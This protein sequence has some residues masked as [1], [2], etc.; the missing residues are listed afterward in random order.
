MFYWFCHFIV[1]WFL[2]I[3]YRFRVEGLENFPQDGPVLVASNHRSNIDPVAIG[4]ALKREI[5]FM[6]KEE[7][8]K[9]P[10]LRFIIIQWKAF[11]VKRGVADRQAIKT[12]LDIMKS[13]K[14]LGLFPEG[15]RSKNG[16]LGPAQ[17][18][19]GL[20]AVKGDCLVVP[21]ALLGTHK[22]SGPITVRIGKPL[23]LSK[24][25]EER[26]DKAKAE[27]V[28]EKI[29]EEIDNLLKK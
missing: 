7:L 22:L 25:G 24:Q 3:F 20:L 15:T 27:K 26:L 13:G 9:I 19:I 29:M 10:F 17:P 5:H 21:I 12:A 23:S 18:G 11:P 14:V 1:G 28:S 16:E 8:F 2:K 4:C 6:A